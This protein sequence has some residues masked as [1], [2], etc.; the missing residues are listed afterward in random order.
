MVRGTRQLVVMVAAA[1]PTVRKRVRALML[2]TRFAATLQS[3]MEGV[4]SVC[5]KGRDVR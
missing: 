1:D 2:K 3:E 4:G 5:E